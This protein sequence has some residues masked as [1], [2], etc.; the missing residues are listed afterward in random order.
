MASQR[1]KDTVQLATIVVALAIL[2]WILGMI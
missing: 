2:A 1:T